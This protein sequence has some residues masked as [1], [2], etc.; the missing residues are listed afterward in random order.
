VHKGEEK[1]GGSNHKSRSRECDVVRIRNQPVGHDVVLDQQGQ[2]FSLA[3]MTS[4]DKQTESRMSS[5]PT[6]STSIL[7]PGGLKGMLMRRGSSYG[8]STHLPRPE[9][10]MSDNA[11]PP[12]P[13]AG[14]EPLYG[15]HS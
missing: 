12:S 2:S 10:A 8:S 3:R 14:K 13:K 7:S 9:T 15:E 5:P 1:E 11:Q 6:S 4:S